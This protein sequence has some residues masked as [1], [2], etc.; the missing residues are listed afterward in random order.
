MKLKVK[1]LVICLVFSLFLNV[2]SVIA[3]IEEASVKSMTYSN[4]DITIY[5]EGDAEQRLD[6]K[7]NRLILTVN[8]V[9]EIVS[10]NDGL[11]YK[12]DGVVKNLTETGQK[13]F[14]VDEHGVLTD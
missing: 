9:A 3:H 6:M 13:V 11:F 1:M 12:K 4:Y 5:Y 14:K 8:N 10:E 2:M 7:E